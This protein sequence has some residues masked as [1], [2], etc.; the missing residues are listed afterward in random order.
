[1]K[2]IVAIILLSVAIICAHAQ[3][4][5]TIDGMREALDHMFAQIDKS[6]VPTGLLIDNA[7]E[8]EDLSK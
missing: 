4:F 5:D 6:F 8:Y 1:M 3:N 2:R 7:I